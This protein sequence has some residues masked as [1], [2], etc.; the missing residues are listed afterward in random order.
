MFAGVPWPAPKAAG[1]AVAFVL[2]SAT[3]PTA[4]RADLRICNNTAVRVSVSLAYT[5]GQNWTRKAG[6]T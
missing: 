1:V 4:A 2:L 3:V 6:G 5:A